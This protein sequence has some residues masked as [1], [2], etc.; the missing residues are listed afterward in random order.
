LRNYNGTLKVE[1]LPAQA[2]DYY[3][4]TTDPLARQI[5][6]GVTRF[7]HAKRLEFDLRIGYGWSN[8]VG[9][10]CR[11]VMNRFT[12]IFDLVDGESS[13]YTRVREFL[14]GTDVKF[15]HFLEAMPHWNYA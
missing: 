14:E 8:V 10:Q 3:C 9:K 12:P 1:R 15:A 11:I 5:S 13:S 4:C 6:P 2:E 7:G